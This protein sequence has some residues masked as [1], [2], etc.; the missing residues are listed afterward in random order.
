MCWM[1]D[2]PSRTRADLRAWQVATIA[3]HGW[4]LQFVEA[5]DRQPS[6]VYTVGL[7][8]FSKAELVASGLT[9]ADGA[10]LNDVAAGYLS[11]EIR[12]GDTVMVGRHQ[13]RLVPDHDTSG[14][15]TAIGL[16]GRHIRALGLRR[17]RR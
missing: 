2:D 15:Y 16:Y 13:Y 1:C 9:V 4:L 8:A 11:G 12:A 7:T 5:D 3:E 14:L 10:D 17:R 6:L